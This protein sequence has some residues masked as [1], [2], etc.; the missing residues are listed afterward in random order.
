MELGAGLDEDQ[1]KGEGLHTGH[2]LEQKEEGMAEVGEVDLAVQIVAV[3]HVGK[4]L[5]AY[6]CATNW[7]SK[8]TPKSWQHLQSILSG[9]VANACTIRYYIFS[10][11]FA[12]LNMLLP[13]RPIC[14]LV[15]SIAASQAHCLRRHG[16]CKTSYIL[17]PKL[18]LKL[19]AT[20]V[21]KDNNDHGAEDGEHGR[22][23]EGERLQHPPQPR[24]LR[25]L[26]KLFSKKY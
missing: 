2:D 15:R 23:G 20:C 12:D 22:E 8:F 13:G 4:V 9:E 18:K 1:G 14:N 25:P 5:R 11:C 3:L 17:N 7:T 19:K 16:E 10:R 26:A 21:G 24:H 6:A